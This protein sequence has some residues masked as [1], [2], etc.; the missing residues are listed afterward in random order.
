MHQQAWH[1]EHPWSEVLIWMMQHNA[2]S[3]LSAKNIDLLAQVVVM[4]MGNI[5]RET[6]VL[7][8]LNAH[9]SSSLHTRTLLKAQITSDPSSTWLVA[10]PTFVPTLRNFGPAMEDSSGGVPNWLLIHIFLPLIST[11][12]YL[13]SSGF[14]CGNVSAEDI[15]LNAYPRMLWHR[16]R[17]YPDLVLPDFRLAKTVDE[18]GGKEDAKAVLAVMQETITSYS[19]AAPFLSLAAQDEE[20]VTI[21]P[22]LLVLQSIT[23]LISTPSP[24]LAI[25]RQHLLLQLIDIRHTSPET[26]PRPI[27]G[28]I[29]SDL[30]MADAD[31]SHA[32]REPSVIRFN[33]KHEEFVKIIAGKR[34][35]MG[36]GG[37]AR[38]KTR[39]IL[40]VI[41]EG[42]EVE[43]LRIMGLGEEMGT[44]EDG[45]YDL[46]EEM[47]DAMDMDVA[48]YICGEW[49]GGSFGGN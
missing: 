19:D 41:F 27:L 20:M 33:R 26:L 44:E 6:E 45:A 17:S 24:T 34:V 11:V 40:V 48:G 21:D 42:R 43:W 8:A 23:T 29:H 2:A 36:T 32:L 38:M 14:S 22:I 3:E 13:H 9:E 37:F 30:G 7:E 12:A 10:S 25:H 28:L 4:K 1:I 15:V 46:E 39:R 16:Y 31:L 47:P 49:S 35:Q 18:A 5:R